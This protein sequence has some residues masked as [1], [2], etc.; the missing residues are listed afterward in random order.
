MPDAGVR[1]KKLVVKEAVKMRCLPHTPTYPLIRTHAP[2][3]LSE[4]CA[5]AHGG[6]AGAGG[7][8]ERKGQG[9]WAPQNA[10]RCPQPGPRG[11]KGRGSD[12]HAARTV[13][14]PTRAA[15]CAVTK[16][17]AMALRHTL[18]LCGGERHMLHVLGEPPRKCVQ[19]RAALSAALQRLL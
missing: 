12:S 16:S 14:P 15:Q 2:T 9:Q 13:R 17:L 18:A 7:S 11:G 5:V 10:K 1:R 4:C 8:S 3:R 6:E 19:K